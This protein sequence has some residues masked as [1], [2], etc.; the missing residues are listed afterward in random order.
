MLLALLVAALAPS[1]LF[2]QGSAASGTIAGSVTDATGAVVPDAMVTITDASTKISTTTKSNKSGLYF[3]ANVAPGTY[4]VTISKEGFKQA[5]YVGQQLIVGQAL[6]VNAALEVGAATQ[7]VEV[8]ATPGAELQT[9]NSTMGT[10]LSGSTLLALPNQNRD[11]TSLLMF[12][13]TT[14]PTF[15]GAE[16]N[17]TGGQV[18]GAM[19]D[20]NTFTLDG[21]QATDDLAGDNN[22]VA[23]NRGYVGPQA[24]IPTPVESIE[25]FKVATN[26]Q[27]ADFAESAGGQ[28]MLVT[29][30]GTNQWHGSGYDYFQADWLDAAGWDLNVVNGTKVKQHQNRFGGSLGGP[31]SSQSVLGGKTYIYGNYEGRRYPYTNGRFERQVPSD[32]LRA[33]IVQFRDAAGNVDQYNLKSSTQCGAAGGQPCDPRGIG[34]N[35]TISQ[36]WNNYMPEPN[37]CAGFG[38]HLNT[39]GYFG[40]LSLP[41]RDDFFVARIDHDFGDK[42]R[43]MGSYRFY[44]LDYP[45]TNQVD[46]GGVIKGDTKGVLAAQSSNPA[47]PRYVVGGLTGTITPTLTNNFTVSYLRNDWN[48]IRAGVPTGLLGVPGGLEVGGET[49]DPLAPMNFDTQNARFRTWNGH[50]WT[51]GDNLNWLK[52]KHFLQFGGS[53]FHW[54]DNHVRND[55]VTGSLTSLVYQINKGTGLLITGDYRPP[56][57][58]GTGATTNCLPDAQIGSWNSLYS[59]ALGFVGT[60]QQLFVR[61]GSNFNLTGSS[62]LQDHSITDGYSL[63]INDSFKVRSDLTINYGLEWGV[64]MP[65]YE[66]NGV[67]DFLTDASGNPVPYASYLNNQVSAASNGQVYNPV[68]GFEPIQAVGS[69]PKYPYS[70]YYGAFSP[71]ISLAWNPAFSSGVLGKLFGNRKTV[72]RGGYGRIY[73]RTNAVNNVLTPLLGYGF[74]QPIRC[75]GAG[76]IGG[77]PGCY[78]H[79]GTDPTN[80]FRIG[81]DGNTSPFPAV[82]QTLPLPAEPGVNSPAASVLF[83]LDNNWRPGI[84][85]QV[86]FSLQR[87]LPGQMI[88]EVGY[89]GRWAKHLYLGQ[90]TDNVPV[91]LKLGG[92]TYAQAYYQLWQANKSGGTSVS[93]QP[94]FETALAGSSYCKGFASCSAAVLANEGSGGT[95]N[96]GV[97][98]AFGVFADIDGNWNFPGCAG[99]LILPSNSQGYT[100]LDMATTG[101]Y[102]NYQ[103]GV[104]TLQKR[105]GHGLTLS[106]NLTYS[107]TL[108]TIGINQEYVEAAPNFSQNL[109]YDYGP[110]PF[111]RTWVANIVADYELPFGRGRRFAT[112]NGILDRV[113]GGWTF[114]PIFSI[115]SGLPLETYTGSCQEFGGGYISWCSGA[116]PLVNTATFG[117]S[118]NLAVKTDC[119]IGV[120]NDPSCPSGGG[121]GA[122]LFKNPTQVYNSYRAAVLG[123]DTTAYDLGPYYG[124]SRWN[125]DFTVAKTTRFTERAGATFYAQFLNAFNHMEYGDPGGANGSPAL[126]LTD[127]ADW[128]SLNSQ[129]NSPRVI[130]LGLRLYF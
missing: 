123:L 100:A 39:C 5:A 111:D 117:H 70:P 12:Q 35:P 1:W 23:G 10:T 49:N 32:L 91:N 18:A 51:Y 114:A 45:S 67:Q 119:N 68:L 105:T 130:E 77:T 79:N 102:A 127:L 64:Q 26:N 41:I 54:W 46:I 19:S 84:D 110:A 90:D 124:Q 87:E 78:G 28:V 50:D 107:R 44:K 25:E 120:N 14:I 34:I 113:I 94:F 38:D 93:P 106:A 69:H 33:G 71:R 2:G 121:Y 31:L 81:V 80:G 58:E 7:T 108:N 3:F 48:W 115:G 4:D 96:L 15:G 129:Y 116:V 76:I 99:C 60:A 126:N 21:G 47:Q 13:P 98:S 37:D 6:T 101:G 75:Q 85:D 55:N 59:E 103:A 95:G 9:L 112:G 30:R 109:A 20:Q 53:I 52:G 122:N 73:D 27:T 22:Y 8:T 42:W 104:L 43:F 63:Y 24:A 88:L 66:L 29:K 83:G 17:T 97:E 16:G 86:D 72:F 65:P 74:G 62:A 89:T 11:A 40:S 82:S 61:G 125:L 57:C 36:L 118:A 92:Q 56:S 128:G